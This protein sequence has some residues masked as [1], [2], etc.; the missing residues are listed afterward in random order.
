MEPPQ[1]QVHP[2][3]SQ[4]RKSPS[5]FSVTRNYD[6]VY[7]PNPTPPNSPAQPTVYTQLQ[8][9]VVTQLKH[10]AGLSK[11]D[12][13]TQTKNEIMTQL[14]NETD[15]D[16]NDV[17][18]H[19][20]E[21]VSVKNDASVNKT[22]GFA[23][24]KNEIDKSDALAQNKNEVVLLKNEAN[25]S[26]N[27]TSNQTKNELVTQLKHEAV[28][29]KTDALNQPKNEIVTQSSNESNVKSEV[30]N[31][32]HSQVKNEVSTVKSEPIITENPVKIENVSTGK[33]VI[34]AQVRNEAMKQSKIESIAQI[35][36]KP[37]IKAQ[38]EIKHTDMKIES[39]IELIPTESTKNTVTTQFLH[40]LT[41]KIEPVLHA[42]HESETRQQ[43][44]L[45][46]EPTEMKN[47]S[48][49]LKNTVQTQ[50]HKEREKVESKIQPRNPGSQNNTNLAST[51]QTDVK[52]AKYT[53][54]ESVI[55]DKITLGTELEMETPTHVKNL[56]YIVPFIQGRN[57]TMTQCCTEPV[58]LGKN[59]ESC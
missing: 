14:R 46:N 31:K 41:H 8:N 22:I 29:S 15:I 57:V 2:A 10:E 7:N 11:T 45:K 32:E 37:A 5:R 39:K 33:K 24:P 49:P 4:P 18:S 38:T 26:K 6:S 25:L 9:E 42:K 44:P 19:K 54:I 47:E 58:K 1:I 53:N 30:V 27:D 51:S 52:Q 50:L 12:A 28:L 59:I 21:V 23:E 13:L 36:D 20:N 56:P 35:Q 34:T 17:F 3:S 40:D 48:S 55:L 43:E 16:K